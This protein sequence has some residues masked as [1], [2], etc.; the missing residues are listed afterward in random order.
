[1]SSGASQ[2]SKYG[3]LS[4]QQAFLECFKKHEFDEA[5]TAQSDSQPQNKENTSVSA[6]RPSDLSQHNTM[7]P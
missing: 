3:T 6:N 1:M 7:D 2:N 5:L 4:S